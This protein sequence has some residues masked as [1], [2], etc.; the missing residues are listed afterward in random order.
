MKKKIGEGIRLY[1]ALFLL[2]ESGSDVPGKKREQHGPCREQPVKVQEQRQGV[3]EEGGGRGRQGVERRR[4]RR[5][6]HRD[7]GLERES[8][9]K[10]QELYLLLCPLVFVQAENP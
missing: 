3:E 4:K 8:S 9:P 10:A 1:F 6:R 5:E 2:L 7:G